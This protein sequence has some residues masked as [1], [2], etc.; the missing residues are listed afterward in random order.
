MYPNKTNFEKIKKA[1]IIAKN[2]N[3]E[4]A[5]PIDGYLLMPLYQKIGNEGFYIICK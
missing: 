5:S 2:N 1:Q 3:L 4:V